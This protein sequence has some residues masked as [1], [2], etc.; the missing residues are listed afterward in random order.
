MP[1]PKELDRVSRVCISTIQHL[2]SML[3]FSGR[4]E[5]REETDTASCVW[6]EPRHRVEN[7]ASWGAA[8]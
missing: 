7:G 6:R 1:N 3:R 8:T 2:Y 5:S 4:A